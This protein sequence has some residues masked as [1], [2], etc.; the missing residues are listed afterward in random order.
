MLIKRS[1]IIFDFSW[2]KIRVFN[3][4]PIDV[5]NSKSLILRAI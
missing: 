4:S 3:K 1:G 5:L 2:S